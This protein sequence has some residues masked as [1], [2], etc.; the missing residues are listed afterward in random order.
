MKVKKITIKNVL[1]FKDEVVFEPDMNTNILIGPNGA[2]KSN[3]MDIINITL[4]HFFIYSYT[5]YYDENS[6]TR[7]INLN[8]SIYGNINDVLLK[9]QGDQ[10]DSEIA[11]EL[12]P[13]SSDIKNIKFIRDNNAFIKNVTS[14]FQGPKHF[15]KSFLESEMLEVDENDSLH[16][17]IKNNELQGNRDEKSNFFLNY[18]NSIEG[19]IRIL[20]DENCPLKPVMIYISPFRSS[21]AQSLQAVL[22]ERTYLEELA[23]IIKN[24][25]RDTSSLIKMASL[26]FSEKRRTYESQKGGWNSFWND[27]ADVKMINN[28]LS[29]FGYDWSLNLRN[30][31]KNTYVIELKKGT[32]TILLTQASSGETELINF[33]F[34]LVALNLTDSIIII[35]EPELHLHPQWL[36]ILRDFF[37]DFANS[38]NN[39]LF[40][41]THSPVFINT[42][43]YPFITRVYK[44]SDDISKIYKVNGVGEQ[45]TKDLL[46]IINA[47]NNEKIFF[48][49][50]V[51]MV[52]GDTD[53]I[54]FRKLLSVIKNERNL[55]TAIEVLQVRG[56]SNYESFK[57][58]LATLNIGCCF[59][60]D[61]D[62]VN[63]FA[64]DKDKVITNLFVTNDRKVLKD[65]IQNP[66]SKDYES[67]LSYLD[68]AITKTDTTG[69]RFFYNYM[70]SFRTK[71]KSDITEEQRDNLYAFIDKLKEEDVYLL[72]DGEI[73]DYFP[74]DYKNKDLNKVIELVGAGFEGWTGSEG[75]NKLKYLLIEI[76]D[77]KIVFS[78]HDRT[79]YD[80]VEE[81]SI[82]EEIKRTMLSKPRNN[83]RISMNQ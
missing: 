18:L 2:G 61:L 28:H 33:I 32:R 5:Y 8:N 57:S 65:V 48:A 43:S 54:V 22:S 11:I 82:D 13:T 77:K 29:K 16:Y 64:K 35:D 9:F 34:G 40:I 51:I 12:Q 6:Q 67:L 21:S 15:I 38:R 14:S 52:E 56:K 17:S 73:E 10:D 30:R 26:F 25:S 45:E 69:L 74:V 66:S 20:K 3:L 53:E 60:G 79:N 7:N 36:W 1:S 83:F 58:F 44:N 81:L 78:S 27:D 31:N 19:L 63:Q 55:N 68:N 42:S 71:L 46:H 24:T 76:V 72:K 47:T 39:Q 70:V 80:Q 75:Y 4:R 62:N 59:I 49:D 23:D 41:S 37:M 50:F